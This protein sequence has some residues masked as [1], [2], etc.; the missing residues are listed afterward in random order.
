[1]SS[2]API[3][4]VD[5]GGLPY[6]DFGTGTKFLNFNIS[7]YGS[8]APLSIYGAFK[9]SA[10]GNYPILLGTDNTSSGVFVALGTTTDRKYKFTL[11]GGLGGT[12]AAGPPAVG[13]AL[14]T[15]YVINARYEDAQSVQ[16]GSDDPFYVARTNTFAV[17]TT[18]KI[19]FTASIVT[20]PIHFYGGV[21]IQKAMKTAQHTNTMSSLSSRSGAT[22]NVNGDGSFIFALGDSLVAAH[23]GAINIVDSA[24]FVSGKTEITLAVP[25]DTIAQQ[26]SAWAAE[27]RTRHA[28]SVFIQVGL[29]DINP[30]TSTAS[31]ITALQGLVDDVVADVPPGCGVYIAQMTPEYTR[32]GTVFGVDQEVAQTQWE[33]INAAIAG[34]GGSPITGVTGRVTSHVALLADPDGKTLKAIYDQGDGI[35]TNDAGRDVNATAWSAFL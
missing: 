29:N 4:K 22:Y 16:V 28:S 32:L 8:N 12:A 27:K 13:L 10:N 18:G 9:L 33:D 31:I 11:S 7:A 17:E 35:H 21:I 2:T 3:Y 15:P 14:A 6:L 30:A 34:T 20:S 5:G 24:N 25:G 19:G 26:A 23:G 1:V